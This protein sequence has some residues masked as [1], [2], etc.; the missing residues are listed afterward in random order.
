M[1]GIFGCVLKKGS[2]APLIHDAL[3]RL[4]YRGYDSCGEATIA[5][6]MLYL[7]KE[8]GRIDAV[9]AQ[10]NLD[11]LPGTIGIGHTRWATHGLPTRINAHP[12]LDCDGKIAVV[13]NGIIGNYDGIQLALKTAGHHYHS[14]TDSEVIVHLVEDGLKLGQ[15]F[16]EAVRQATLKLEGSFTF[17][18]IS[19][20][21]PDKIVCV[22]NESPL[23]LGVG[24]EGMFCASD[25]PAFLALTRKAIYL[26]NRE[27][28]VITSSSYKIMRI[29][30]GVEVKREPEIVDWNIEMAE[31]KGF[32]HFTLKEIYE[33]PEALRNSF[34]LRERFLDLMV[35]FVDKS[36]KLFMVGCGTAYHA[37]LVA[38]YLFSKLACSVAQP[39]IASEFIEQYGR[40]VDVDSVVFAVSQSGET[41]D[42]LSAVDYAKQNAATVLSLINT[43]GSTLRMASWVYLCQ[44]SGP[45]IGVAATK[46]FTGQLAVLSHI[47]FRLAKFRGKM[48]HEEIKTLE[49]KLKQLPDLAEKA[50]TYQDK[51]MK[52]IAEK[53]VNADK[54]L[55]VGKGINA[56][57]AS[58]GALKLLELS[59]IPALAF[60]AGE[61]KHGPISLISL[62]TP[63]VF[64]CPHDETYKQIIN[65]ISEMKARGASIIALVEE[66]DETIKAMAD[67]V[68]EVPK[69]SSNVL[70]PILFVIPLQFLAY[71]ISVKKGLDPDHPR[72]LAKSVT[73]K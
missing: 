35:E 16:V 32:P 66:G 37:C 48:S 5:G 57:T 21:E 12:H 68:V 17:A 53:Y 10:L 72:N 23:V 9:H 55:F 30:D 15:S 51:R 27:M 67:E 22:R 58:E 45:E 3:K 60:P 8:K 31:K 6:G 69:G 61:S 47:A 62:G 28:A 29:S 34:R 46:T 38:S 40:T 13:H 64:I 50:L 42:T 71:H 19:V 36:E 26:Q 56:A 73:V 52:E 44:Q 70:S 49:E 20:V 24:S 54:F 59:Y 43:M 14:G 25:V 4:E 33:Q 7:K 18:V 39:V 11:D 1:C 41:A 63:V 65:S 2:V